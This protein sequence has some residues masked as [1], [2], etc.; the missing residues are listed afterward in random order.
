MLGLSYDSVVASDLAS[1]FRKAL[2]ARVAKI[3]KHC[4]CVK[5][6][7]HFGRRVMVDRSRCFVHAPKIAAHN[8][9]R[10]RLMKSFD[11]PNLTDAQ[12]ARLMNQREGR[13]WRYIYGALVEL[14][15]TS[16]S[17]GLRHGLTRKQA[18]DAIRAWMQCGR[19]KA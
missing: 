14:E 17:V 6:Q 11:P 9:R 18:V 3:M 12:I 10:D 1:I 7:G 16:W 2:E 15:G 4:A 13:S 19:M 8:Q 5:M